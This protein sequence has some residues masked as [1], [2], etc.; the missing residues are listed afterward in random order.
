MIIAGAPAVRSRIWTSSGRTRPVGADIRRRRWQAKPAEVPAFRL[1]EAEDAGKRVLDLFG[2]LGRAA[3]LQAY[4]VVDADT[5][6]VR[7]LFAAQSFDP[8]AAVDGD[9]DGCRVDAGTSGPEEACEIVHA[10]QY[11]H[12]GAPGGWPCRYQEVRSDGKAAPE[13]RA[14]RRPESG[15]TEPEEFS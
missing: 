10:L 7:D 1:V 8:A 13:R 4:V 12:A 3:L 2:G 11:G 6:Q 14:P 9:A 15:A 5:G